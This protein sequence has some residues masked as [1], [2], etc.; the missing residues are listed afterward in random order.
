MK[1][2]DDLFLEIPVGPLKDEFTL[3]RFRNRRSLAR[4]L[5]KAWLSGADL[6]D[7]LAK[8]K[9][10][11]GYSTMGKTEQDGVRKFCSDVRILAR[12]W[13]LTSE[14]ERSLFLADGLVYA[15]MLKIIR[16]R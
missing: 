7:R 6:E 12:G 15:A 1:Q 3:Q 14:A 9:T 10:D 5:I 4:Q 2:P 8:L 16:S 13:H 11:V